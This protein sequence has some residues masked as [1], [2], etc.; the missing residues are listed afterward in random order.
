MSNY[1]HASDKRRQRKANKF[2]KYINKYFEEKKETPVPAEELN[3]LWRTEY[4]QRPA[5]EEEIRNDTNN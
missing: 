3:K 5:T 4:L 2:E 1:R